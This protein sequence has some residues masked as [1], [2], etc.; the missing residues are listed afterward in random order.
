MRC[1]RHQTWTRTERAGIETR[2]QTDEGGLFGAAQTKCTFANDLC[3][4]NIIINSALLWLDTMIL[5]CMLVLVSSMN[6][7]TFP[8]L[9]Q[10]T[11]L[12]RSAQPYN[13]DKYSPRVGGWSY[14]DW[15]SLCFIWFCNINICD[16]WTVITSWWIFLFALLL[17]RKQRTY[18]RKQ[19]LLEFNLDEIEGNFH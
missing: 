15:G 8:S 16:G 7:R 3:T 4:C 1:S 5:E 9:S 12:Y 19:F 6:K 17:I 18:Y 11:Y 2:E 10:S 13:L 14:F